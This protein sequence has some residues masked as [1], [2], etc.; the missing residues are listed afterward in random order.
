[1]RLAERAVALQLERDVEHGVDLVLGPVLEVDD[2]PAAQ[3]GLHGLPLYSIAPRTSASS[4][5]RSDDA[6]ER[7]DP[8]AGVA[9]AVDVGRQFVHPRQRVQD[10]RVALGLGRQQLAGD[11]VRRRRQPV[12]GR[13]VDAGL[14]VVGLDDRLHVDDVGVRDALLDRL[15]PRGTSTLRSSSSA[16]NSSSSD[17][18]GGETTM[19]SMSN[20]DMAYRIECIVRMRM[21]PTH[22]TREPVERALVLPDRVEVGEHLGRMLAPPVAAVD[23]RDR[24]PLGGLVR[25]ALLVV[26]HRDDVAV[27]LQHVDGV[28]DRLLVEV[29][30]PGHLGVGE[31]EHMPAEAVHG[32]LGGQPGARARLV[33]RGE[34][35]LVTRAGRC[36]AAVSA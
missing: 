19:A 6:V 14:G 9:G 18:S 28:L 8:V 33:E 29:A 26:T 35:R 4:A 25:R 32:G 16:L 20:C 15:R 24:R 23:D 13:R 10:D 12:L 7:L 3:V 27:V 1:M 2:V 22:S 11:L 31:A 21:S 34:Q 36:C 30:G 17:I 5:I